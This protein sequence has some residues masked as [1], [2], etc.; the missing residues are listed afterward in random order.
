MPQRRLPP[1]TGAAAVAR[2]EGAGRRASRVRDERRA[3]AARPRVPRAADRAVLG[4]YREHQVGRR[5]RGECAAPALPVEHRSLPAV[6]SRV[7]A[8]GQRAADPADAEE[9][10]RTGTR[11]VAAR[12]S[13]PGAHGTFLAG[14]G[15]GASSRSAPTAV[16]GGDEPGCATSPA[17]EA[18][19][20]GRPTGCRRS[21]VQ[22]SCWRGQRTG[23][24]VR[25]RTSRSTTRRAISSTRSYGTGYRSSDG[26]GRP[27]EMLW[28]G[29]DPD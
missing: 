27:A 19:S 13:A 14:R 20:A 12:A 10:L 15:A 17:A 25:S 18:G 4:R 29:G 7:P 28:H 3:P 1:G 26:P 16:P 21:G 9:R 22:R 2:R 11:R 24:A 5:H 8:G 6:R 23:Q